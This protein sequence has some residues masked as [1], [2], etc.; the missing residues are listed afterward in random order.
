MA[1]KRAK[2]QQRTYDG[3]GRGTALTSGWFTSGTSADAEIWGSLKILRDRARS[4][5]QNDPYLS[6][7]VNSLIDNV[8]DKGITLQS[9]VRMRRRDEYDLRVNHQIEAWFY[10]WAEN[11]SWC[12]VRGQND[13]YDFQRIILGSKVIAGEVLVRIVR[14]RFGDSPIPL[15][16]EL[17]E[18]DQLDD[19]HSV[20][21][22]PSGNEIRM[23][24]EVDGWGRPMA[25][26]ILPNHPGDLFFRNGRNGGSSPVRVGAEN[27]LHLVNR[28]G[29]RPGQTRGVSAL[30]SIL[31]RLKNLHSYEEAEVVKARYQ[32]C[33]GAYIQS[34]LPETEGEID[35][36]GQPIEYLEP[37]LKERLRPGETIAAFD[38]SSPNPN[39][40][41]FIKHL[42]RSVAK[43]AGVSAYT[44]TG[45]VTDANFSSM[46]T[47][48][49]EERKRFKIEQSLLIQEFNHPVY[50]VWLE[51]AVLSGAVNLPGYDLNPDFYLCDQWSG[52]G[53]DWVDP[54]KDVQAT[55]LGLAIGTQTLTDALAS[56]G[57]DLEDVLAKRRQ[58]M[59]LF[60]KYG[61]PYPDFSGA[62]AAP[63]KPA[64]AE[65]PEDDEPEEDDDE[66]DPPARRLPRKAKKRWKRR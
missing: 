52:A 65:E 2:K 46:R 66:D 11:P 35:Q 30:H 48:L 23:G 37:G 26:W 62:L 20:A 16:L 54:L 33:I 59:A 15:A 3:A 44:A 9:K 41:D 36:Y 49:L 39:L 4:L 61:V 13:F 53:W 55:E 47:A 12:D 42:L 50:R 29:W 14:R 38:P 25:Y 31:L 45:D 56:L 18:A 43:G 21:Q 57:H 19:T 60:A 34:D 5:Y 10:K 7:M 51:Q 8:V 58:E 40:P 6:G 24:V 22:G 64:L 27:I 1:K 32:A 17:I 63:S 28:K